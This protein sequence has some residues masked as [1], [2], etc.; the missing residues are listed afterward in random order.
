[1]KP[2]DKSGYEWETIEK[3]RV[4]IKNPILIEGMP[5][6]GNVGKIAMDVLIEETKA[7]VYMSF[8]STSMPNSVFVNEENLIELPKIILY[9]KRIKNQ[10][11]LFLTGDVQPTTEQSSYLFCQMITDIF[12][13]LKGKHIVT[14]GGIGLNEI[15][16]NP[17]VY[18]TGN[19]KRFVE[20]REGR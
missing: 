6:I 19:D 2:S 12:R 17:K 9:H 13:E 4:R 11:F 15:P 10:D 16:E 8:F 18:L 20:E 1:M 7:S 3:N 5:G 14:L